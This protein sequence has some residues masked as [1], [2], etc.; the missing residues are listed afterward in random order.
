MNRRTI[1]LAA[2]AAVIL[3]AGCGRDEREVVD[4]F[5][6][7]VSMG[8]VN[9][10][11][12][13]LDQ[14]AVVVFQGAAYPGREAHRR[15]LAE[16]RSRHLGFPVGKV[17][18]TRAGW[19]VATGGHVSGVRLIEGEGFRPASGDRLA[20]QIEADVKRGRITKITYDLTPASKA[21]LGARGDQV[22]KTAAVF[23]GPPPMYNLG[24]FAANAV[25]QVGSTRLE[26][27][28][29]IAGWVL[30][31]RPAALGGEPTVEGSMVRWQGTFSTAA[32]RQAGAA[33]RRARFEVDVAGAT[34]PAPIIRRYTVDYEE[35]APAPPASQPA[36][37]PAPA[38]S[39]P[40][41][42]QP[43]SASQPR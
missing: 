33:A 13:L 43:A 7:H 40:A 37:A 32:T 17:D 4:E 8:R 29:A 16:A 25:L 20:V 3:G 9:E 5:Q 15:W 11:L 12:G 24:L 42:S 14:N 22:R 39:Q 6:F 26:G 34:T 1:L 19:Q 18:G 21:A 10:A 41:P 31:N 30:T 28:P 36:S 27:G 35:P 23:D 2:L 38:P